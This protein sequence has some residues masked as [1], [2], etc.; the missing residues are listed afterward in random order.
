MNMQMQDQSIPYAGCVTQ[1][2]F[3]IIFVCIDNLL[4]AVMAYDRY[5]TI[6]TLYIMP[7]S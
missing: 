4:L 6:V 5:V 2:Y 7:S 1:V 3:F